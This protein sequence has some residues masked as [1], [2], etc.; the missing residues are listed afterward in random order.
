[1]KILFGYEARIRFRSRIILDV[2]ALMMV[3]GGQAGKSVPSTTNLLTNRFRRWPRKIAGY[4]KITARQDAC[5]QIIAGF[6]WLAGYA[7]AAEA[8]KILTAKDR[9]DTLA[10]LQNQCRPEIFSTGPALI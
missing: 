8:E 4:E 10:T 1:M 9:A 5:G 6:A 3:S 7:D 2:H